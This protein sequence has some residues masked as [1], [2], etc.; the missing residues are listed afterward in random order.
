MAPT[1]KKSPS[2]PQ[3]SATNRRTRRPSEEIR[4]A[5]LGIPE[6]AAYL[7]VHKSTIRRAITAN[8]LPAYRIG[9]RIIKVKIADLDAMLTPLRGDV[10]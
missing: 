1:R 2:A 9:N 3:P 5:Y 8:R 6:A 7:D 10:A 4:P